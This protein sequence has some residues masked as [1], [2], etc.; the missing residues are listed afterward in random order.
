MISLPIE[1][2][3]GPRRWRLYAAAVVIGTAVT[4]ISV[5]PN[6]LRQRTAAVADAK[7][8]AIEGPPC[9]EL[10]LAEAARQPVA[11][12]SFG[13][14]HAGFAYAYGH[15][16]CAEIHAEGGR[17][18]FSGF[19]VCQFTSPG[20]I[21]VDAAGTTTLFAPGLGERAT[22]TVQDGKARCVMAGKFYGQLNF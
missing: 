11:T 13:Y 17:S 4:A 20:V 15:V 12:R 10:P 3:S 21:L 2:G 22:V 1:P 19:P 9:P 5:A 18:L 6:L 16:A 7:A 14:A 8:W